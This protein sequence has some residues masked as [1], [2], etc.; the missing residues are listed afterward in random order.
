VNNALP[1]HRASVRLFEG[2]GLGKRG[3]A[4]VLGF[5]GGLEFCGADFASQITTVVVG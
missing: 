5:D 4:A 2:Y 3:C 1:N